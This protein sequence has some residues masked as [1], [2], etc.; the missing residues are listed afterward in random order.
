MSV[1]ACA[2]PSVCVWNCGAVFVSFRM[3]NTSK[4]HLA[5]RVVADNVSR[6]YRRLNKMFSAFFLCSRGKWKI[7]RIHRQRNYLTDCS[8]LCQQQYGV[9]RVPCSLRSSFVCKCECDSLF[10]IHTFHSSADKSNALIESCTS[11]L[12]LVYALTWNFSRVFD[13]LFIYIYI[14]LSLFRNFANRSSADYA[15]QPCGQWRSI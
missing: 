11:S 13:F 2:T 1:S 14:Y 6:V 3:T 4:M 15:P 7:H 10:F 12:S 8:W 5:A 9:C